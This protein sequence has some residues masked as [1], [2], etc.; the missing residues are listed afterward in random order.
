MELRLNNGWYLINPRQIRSVEYFLKVIDAYNNR[1]YAPDAG[2]E[3]I[4]N[5]QMEDV[6]KLIF[7]DDTEIQEALK[8]IKEKR[9]EYL[10]IYFDKNNHEEYVNKYLKQH[11]KKLEWHIEI[12]VLRQKENQIF[13]I[14]FTTKAKA[15]EYYTNICKSLSRKFGLIQNR[16]NNKTDQIKKEET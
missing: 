9:E 10:K 15:D 3:T 4:F 5:M 6:I 2:I 12:E 8:N 7:T 14:P 13:D 16:K 11:S 1:K